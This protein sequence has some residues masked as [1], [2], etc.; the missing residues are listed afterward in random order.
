MTFS[1]EDKL[2]IDDI[3]KNFVLCAKLKSNHSKLF[4]TDEFAY[5]G[6]ANFSFGS[7]NNYESGV[8][9]N[10]KEIILEIRKYFGGELLEKSEFTNVPETIDPFEILP[11][12]LESVEELNKIDTI[13]DLYNSEEK[14]LIV[15]LRYLDDIQKHLEDMGYPVPIHF[16]WWQLYMYLYE[17]KHVPNNIFS[18]F[19]SYIHKLYP[20]LIEVT[21]FINKQYETIGRIEFLKKIKV[22]K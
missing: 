19:K 21:N 8:I 15:D 4:I 10:N 18:N 6:S 3:F 20:F 5:I 7:N 9:F 2:E 11:R 1:A 16:D 13:E 12:I 14:F 22:I 17:E